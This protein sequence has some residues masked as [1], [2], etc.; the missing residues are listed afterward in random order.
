MH[1]R[2]SVVSTLSQ[3]APSWGIA[4]VQEADAHLSSLPSDNTFLQDDETLPY[5][6]LRWWRFAM[7]IVLHRRA[8]PFLQDCRTKGRACVIV[9]SNEPVKPGTKLV[10]ADAIVLA[11]VHAK[12]GDDIAPMLSDPADLLKDTPSGARKLLVTGTWTLR[13]CSVLVH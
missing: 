10:G 8:R 2:R 12:A 7:A 1:Q 11:G 13:T 4:M 3:I 5:H 6:V 9:L